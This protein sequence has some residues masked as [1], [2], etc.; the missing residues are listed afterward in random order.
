VVY[1]TD[2]LTEYS[3][4]V[5]HQMLLSTLVDIHHITAPYKLSHYYY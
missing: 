4:G 3:A 1:N 2:T 5:A